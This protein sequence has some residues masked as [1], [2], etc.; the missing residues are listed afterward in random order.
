MISQY[1]VYY[2]SGDGWTAHKTRA[3]AMKA[4]K[5]Y[6]GQIINTWKAQ[7]QRGTIVNFQIQREA[8]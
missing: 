2:E 5:A 4:V 8:Q 3:E 7:G 1:N 6:G